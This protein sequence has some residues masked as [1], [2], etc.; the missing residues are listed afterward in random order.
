VA[1]LTAVFHH[2]GGR[3][4][5]RPAQSAR[6]A[7]RPSFAVAVAVGALAIVA[8]GETR[9][10]AP[11]L[12][13]A[14]SVYTASIRPGASPKAF[15]AIEIGPAIFNDLR[16]A[17]DRLRLEGSGSLLTYKSPL[18][19]VATG[20][21]TITVSSGRSGRIV[22]LYGTDVANRLATGTPRVTAF[23]AVSRFVLCGHAGRTL[24]VPQFAG[25]FGVSQPGCYR[26]EVSVGKR[27]TSRVVSFGADA[28]CPTE[29]LPRASAATSGARPS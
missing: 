5:T 28:G 26:L 21:A 8:C 22:L 4:L 10:H 11:A 6:T 25:G 16:G 3:A 18:T 14:D 15:N 17:R 24:R 2:R 19:I 20:E 1:G 23:P 29:A 9:P 13:C 12:T 7:W 27:S